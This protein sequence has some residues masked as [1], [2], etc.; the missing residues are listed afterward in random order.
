MIDKDY[1][2]KVLKSVQYRMIKY[3]AINERIN[4]LKLYEKV[5]PSL[6]AISKQEMI[7][8]V[9]EDEKD[10]S[11]EDYIK[12]HEFSVKMLENEINRVTKAIDLISKKDNDC[13]TILYLIYFQRKTKSECASYLRYD[14][15]KVYK[16]YDEAIKLFAQVY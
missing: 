14:K 1:A 8:E 6:N 3:Q 16:L 13:A 7:K 11:L 4:A 10:K 9:L 2:I 15:A 5:A 12:Y